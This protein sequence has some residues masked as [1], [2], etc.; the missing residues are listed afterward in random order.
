MGGTKV[1]PVLNRPPQRN[2]RNW[3]PLRAGWVGEEQ[4]NFTKY[5]VVPTLRR[6][7]RPIFCYPASGLLAVTL[8]N[9]TK[10]SLTWRREN[11]SYCSPP[12]HHH[13]THPLTQPRRPRRPQTTHVVG[14]CQWGSHGP[15]ND[16]PTRKSRFTCTAKTF[17]K[18]THLTKANS[19][20]KKSKND[21]FEKDNSEKGHIWKRTYLKKDKSDQKQSENWQ[22]WR[23]RVWKQTGLEREDW[24]PIILNETHLKRTILEKTN[25]KNKYGKEPSEKEPFRQGQFWRQKKWKWNL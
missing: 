3:I 17:L 1:R 10:W 23:R 25:Q 24:T 4:C 16:F 11:M 19:E 21:K 8:E 6:T 2:L 14:H 5:Q 20:Q 12:N 9:E 18:K 13:H 7:I 15:L 22:L